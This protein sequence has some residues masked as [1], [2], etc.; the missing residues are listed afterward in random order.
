VSVWFFAGASPL[1]WVHRSDQ[2]MQINADALSCVKNQTISRF[3]SHKISLRSS[4]Q[5]FDD[6]KH[7]S[8]HSDKTKEGH[9]L[10]RMFSY[11]DLTLWLNSCF[12]SPELINH[13]STHLGRS[14]LRRWCLR[15]SLS[16]PVISA[17]HA[18]IECLLLPDNIP[19]AQSLQS[20]LRG[21]CQVPKA[22]ALLR[23]GRGK[24]SEWRAIAKVS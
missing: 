1:T 19:M 13:T 11:F 24:L 3:V 21:L 14:L 20:N 2:V 15:P 10:F 12:N 22:M 7:A 4:L 17:R 18:A 9:S 6:E 5:I 16:I 8:V 23:T